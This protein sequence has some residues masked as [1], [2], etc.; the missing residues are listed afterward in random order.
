MQE[1]AAFCQIILAFAVSD[2][3]VRGIT[4][5]L[6]FAQVRTRDGDARE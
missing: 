1:A 2:G 4:D 5:S 3:S 6:V